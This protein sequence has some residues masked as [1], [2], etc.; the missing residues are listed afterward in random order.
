M[1]LLLLKTI[2]DLV[3]DS[4][5]SIV[6]GYEPMSLLNQQ[7][8]I[9][10]YWKMLP[11]KYKKN[12]SKLYVI[13]PQ[14]GIK[15]FFELSRVFVSQKFYQK[16]L[17][18]DY[19][20][21][22]QA[23]IPAT[24]LA[25]PASYI[26]FEDSEKGWKPIGVMP[27]LLKSFDN[28]L[29]TTK[30]IADCCSFIRLYGL[31]RKGLFRIAGDESLLSLVKTRLYNTI[32]G[33]SCVIIG[34]D[35]DSR[36]ESCTSRM[37]YIRPDSCS[38]VA[39]TS[40]AASGSMSSTLGSMSAALTP[41]K[42]TGKSSGNI[43][44][45]STILIQDIDTVAQILKLS[46]RDLPDPLITADAYDR[47]LKLTSLLSSDSSMLNLTDEMWEQE[48]MAVIS[49][50]PLEHKDTLINLLKFLAEVSVHS[51]DNLMDCSNLSI[52]FTPTVMTTQCTDPMEALKEMKLGQTIVTKLITRYK[53]ELLRKDK[54]HDSSTSIRLLD[55]SND[56]I[57]YNELEKKLS[58]RMQGR[59]TS[60]RFD[61]VDSKSMDAAPPTTISETE[62]QTVFQVTEDSK[63][64]NRNM[65]LGGSR[66]RT[67]T[68]TEEHNV[69]NDTK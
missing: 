62:T 58:M 54:D 15:M 27:P 1:L 11:R 49:T 56:S 52:V 51:N 44:K 34:E 29:G 38:S 14:L 46:I 13:H 30:L 16:L 40:S 28:V 69:D 45:I 20:S 18:I 53:N 67:R 3:H 61:R 4:S 8:I 5:F 41:G 24:S 47:L 26:R 55:G 42:K 19:I 48:A 12:L 64:G 37:S 63:F 32:D 39:S 35:R 25:L 43:N 66:Q 59:I 7:P 60:G 9:Y 68:G 6:Y 22:F 36:R 23:I 31:K 21:D 2:N 50:M 33:T 10:K 17:Y 65:R 57:T